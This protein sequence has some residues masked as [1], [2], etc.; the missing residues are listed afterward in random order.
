MTLYSSCA[1]ETPSLGIPNILVDVN[2]MATKYYED[3]LSNYHTKIIKTIEEFDLVLNYLVKLNKN[4]IKQH[5]IN[6]FV[7]N[8]Q[9]RIK[10]YFKGINVEK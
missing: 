7:N 2:N 9:E 5:N 8:Y 6:V 1:L 3:L 10:N 4:G